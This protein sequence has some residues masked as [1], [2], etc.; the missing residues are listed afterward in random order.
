MKHEVVQAVV[1]VDD[2][3][4]AGVQRRG[5]HV[6][7]QP[8]D[9]PLHRLDRLRDRGLILLA[10][11][12]DL[13]LEIVAGLAIAVQTGGTDVDPVQGGDHSAH[14]AINGVAL[15]RAHARQGLIPKYAA[16]N[17]FHDV[18]GATDH[19]FVFAQ[20]E[21]ARHGHLAACKSAHDRELALDRMRR[22]QQLGHRAGLAAH[23]VLGL[24]RDQLVRGVGLTALELLD[25]ERPG[26]TLNMS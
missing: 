23:H 13:A 20:A 14:F 26:V 6:G 10:P 12:A 17:E 15:G 16:L 21:H 19:G 25:R 18:E 24:R 4:F 7:R 9:Q 11:T 1:A 8:F 3:D 2:R 5:R 22:G